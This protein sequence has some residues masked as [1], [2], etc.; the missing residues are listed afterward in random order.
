MKTDRASPIEDNFESALA[1][2]KEIDLE[3]ILRNASDLGYTSIGQALFKA[4]RKAEDEDRHLNCEVLMLLDK[5]CW[6]HVSPNNSDSFADFEIRFFKQIARFVKNSLLRGKLANMVWNSQKHRDIQFALLAIDS[7]MQLPL[8]AD[9]WFSDGQECWQRAIDLSRRIGKAAEDRLDRI[10]SSLISALD[11]AT[12]ERGFYGYLL[13]E[14]LMTGK[15]ARDHSTT[16]ATKL[17]SLAGK[18]DNNGNFHTAGRFYFASA[19]WFK[20]SGDEEKSIEMTVLEAGMFKKEATDRIASDTPSY[21]LAAGFL[22]N[23]IQVYRKIPGNYWH[24]HQVDQEIQELRTLISEYNPR[25]MGEL[26]AVNTP[27]V[28]VSKIVEEARNAVTGKP[29]LEALKAFADLHRVDVSNLREEALENLSRSQTHRMFPKVYLS[30][31]GRVIFKLPAF[32]DSLAPEEYELVVRAEMNEFFYGIRV[33]IAVQAK[34]L[35]ALELLNLEHN[36]SEDDFIDIARRSPAVPK[37]RE[38]LFGKSLAFGFSQ[39]FTTSIHLLT[40]QIEHMVR[41]HLNA[42][43]VPTIKTEDGIVTEN[44]LGTLIHLEETKEILGDNLTYEI[45]TLF[46]DPTGPNLRNNIAHGLFDD[47]Q[48]Y[49]YDSVYAWWLGF[50]VAF[51]AYWNTLPQNFM[52]EEE[53]QSHGD[54]PNWK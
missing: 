5:V 6:A 44:G 24:R 50:K 23:A 41:F 49:T 42:A 51:N 45:S 20:F 7:Y 28:D 54:S 11:S 35:P 8:D 53:I 36:L 1:T 30:H 22:E 16:V 34:I 15:L 10:E 43:G 33:L 4:A 39:D 26:I 21:R 2:F 3:A 12:T 40:P 19:K 27:G 14:T 48:C 37:G 9:T 32:S 47:K 52:S 17:K 25:A 31:D 46:C 38:N 18:F 13:A 29:L